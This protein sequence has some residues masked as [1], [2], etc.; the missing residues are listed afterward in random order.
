[1]TR[2]T[3]IKPLTPQEVFLGSNRYLLA[4]GTTVQRTKM[5][6]VAAALRTGD[7]THADDQIASSVIWSDLTGG[8]GVIN[9]NVQQSPD[10]FAD[11][12]LN[13][14]VKDYWTLPP[15]VHTIS[16]P[17]AVGAAK[18]LT[19]LVG[20][21]SHRGYVYTMFDRTP[22]RISNLSDPK[23]E[24]Y[25]SVGLAWVTS[26]GT[27]YATTDMLESNPVV[28]KSAI[29]FPCG[30]GA[31]G[32]LLRYDVAA[33]TFSKVTAA[34]AEIPAKRLAVF[35]EDLYIL[36]Y[37]GTIHSVD[38]DGTAVTLV[39]RGSVDTFER[40]NGLVV[41]RN[42]AND[43]A[44]FITTEGRVLT[45]D[46][47][48]G[49]TYPAGIDFNNKDPLNGSGAAVWDGD[50]WFGKDANLHQVTS[51]S[52]VVRGP[53]TGD[54]LV[55]EMQGHVSDTDA[56]MD[57]YL[58]YC[59]SGGQ[60]HRTSSIMAYNRRGHH[61]LV[62]SVPTSGTV[63]SD[64][65]IRA[66]SAVTMGASWIQTPGTWGIASNKAYCAVSAG[67][68]N[69][70]LTT[71]RTLGG[72][73]VG[74]NQSVQVVLSTN[75]VGTQVIFRSDGLGA[76]ATY[77]AVQTT[78]A[79][80]RLVSYA[81]G[82]PTTLHNVVCTPANGDI[83]WIDAFETSFSLYVNSALLHQGT[84]PTFYPSNIYAGL[85]TV[86]ITTPRFGTF[87]LYSLTE[88]TRFVHYHASDQNDTPGILL[89]NGGTNTA[90]QV[91][92]LQY[93]KLFDLTDNAS[94]FISSDFESSGYL[95]LPWF[96]AGL[97]DVS[98]T[99]ITVQVRTLNC[100]ATEKVTVS[101]ALNDS[102]SFTQ[103]KD[104]T[105]A[106]ASIT[107]NGLTTLYFD[108]DRLGTAFYKI[109]LYFTLASGSATLSPV[110]VFAKLRYLREFDVLYS[111][112]FTLDLTQNQPGNR[113][114]YTAIQEL[115]TLAESKLLTQFAPHSGRSDDTKDVLVT[116][117][118]GPTG[119]ANDW[120]GKVQMTV[121]E[122][123]PQ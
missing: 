110:V 22:L 43:P 33:Q 23:A 73:M 37:D 111:Y 100:T 84:L 5:T 18:N 25:D 10:R 118:S 119:Q 114:P 121:L 74:A 86:S 48:A 24:Y 28:W 117:Y 12:T 61:V 14:M 102:T 98:K 72:S 120:K 2:P 75:P 88:P 36:K 106:S 30:G 71:G 3:V 79:G 90:T 112:N 4:P 15:K 80:Y 51:G 108:A 123:S 59:V 8:I 49:K 63:G 27:V 62:K 105:G 93:V 97:A 76:A 58:I 41:A 99:A 13:T 7:A 109:R 11:S 87:V 113:T 39:A 19:R 77:Y 45:H 69:Q 55:K 52:R 91:T 56:S 64:D 26:G 122:V 16:I 78:A 21:V 35:D 9:M 101:Y 20:A 1:M 50:I 96:D 53:N 17:S 31:S 65:F 107:S 38:T 94:Q 89:F 104:S 42:L 81:A 95:Y 103:M 67:T 29:W 6:Q 115:D 40:L 68:L 85:G 54:G 44:P 83:L 57:N 82:T 46:Y 66:D 32:V 70:A 34:A 116:T 60:T 92:N 47:F